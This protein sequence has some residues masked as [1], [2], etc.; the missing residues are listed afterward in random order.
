M[1]FTNL[2]DHKSHQCYL[3]SQIYPRKKGSKYVPHTEG[4][5]CVGVLDEI[6]IDVASQLSAAPKGKIS[7]KRTEESSRQDLKENSGIDELEKRLA[8]LRNP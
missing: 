1:S 8:A 5:S 2:S 3:L 4:G 6:G 7:G